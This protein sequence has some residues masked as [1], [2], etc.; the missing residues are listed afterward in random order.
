M[1]TPLKTSAVLLTLS[2]A[3]SA[4]AVSA[5]PVA[6][7]PTSKTP[8][9][10]T[11]AAVKT[12]A[13]ELNGS[14]IRDQGFQPSGVKE[15]LVPLRAVAEALGFTLTW[16]QSSKTAELTKGNIFTTVK[17]GEDRYSVN[18]MSTTLGAAPRTLENKL[19]VP[20]S[21]VSEVL[22]Q[23][24]SVEGQKIVIASA[25][26][27]MTENGVITAVNADGK[28]QSIH[29]KGTGT[30]GLVLN[31]GEDTVFRKAD[32]T[33]LTL[34]DLQ[35]GMTIEAEH[36]L[37]STRSLPPQTPA[38]QITVLDSAQPADLLGTEGT[39]EEIK[40]SQDG[41]SMIRINGSGLTETSQSEIILNLS[42]DTVY[43]NESG[44][45]VE[46]GAVVQGAKVIGFYGPVLTRSLPAIGTAW[47]I[48]VV[49]AQQQ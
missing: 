16:N 29:I 42:K 19:F 36:A 49:T 35:I 20:A 8:Q 13:I 31:I 2:L 10:T 11:I 21:F 41:T 33:K 38:Y 5:A 43:V 9:A 46:A 15:P 44:E 4:G 7:S 18:K 12:F 25:V 34:A 27:H 22:Q 14:V 26:E 28:Y 23:T 37:F 45:P 30:S 39:V 24:I 1:K 47:K 17:S 6:S 32:G 3:L 48:V 40:T